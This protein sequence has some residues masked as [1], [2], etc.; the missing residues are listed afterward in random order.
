MSGRWFRYYDEALDDPKVQRLSPHLFRVWVNLLCLASKNGGTLSSIDDIAF[1]LRISVQDAKSYVDDLILAGLIDISADSTLAPHNWRARQ[2]VSDSST[3]RTRKYR[4]KK[5]KTGGNVTRNV[6]VTAQNRTDSDTESESVTTSLPKAAREREQS[7]DSDLKGGRGEIGRTLTARA[8]G[9]GLPVAELVGLTDRA[10][11]RNAGAYFRKLC[12][13][14]LRSR[15]PGA[16]DE[17]LAKAINGNREAFTLI[18][19]ALMEAG[20][21]PCPL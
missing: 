4:E 18:T 16:S 1:R 19:L 2:Y 3:I 7:E 12:V 10:R 21:C 5:S 17:L 20:P 13:S 15:V 14:R 9:L 8:E 11:P 6:T